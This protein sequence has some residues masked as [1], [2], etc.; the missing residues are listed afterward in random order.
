MK[1]SM[2]QRLQTLA[3]ALTK[4][5]DVV[6]LPGPP[7]TDF[8]RIFM[9]HKDKEILPGIEC[10]RAEAWLATKAICAHETSHILF[11]CKKT[12]DDFIKWAQSSYPLPRL[13]KHVLNCLEDGRAERAM[14]ARYPQ[15]QSL[16]TFSNNYFFQHK[17]WGT[18][19]TAFL[20]G[21]ISLSTVGDI[22][23]GITEPEITGVLFHL[24]ENRQKQK[25]CN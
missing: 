9:E 23:K 16:F 4:R 1:E 18:G 22:P 3:R 14:G 25:I 5:N 6:V 2:R 13:A 19:L 12:W 17:E 11:T 15:T 20:G 10:S 21:L 7:C 24:A 8:T